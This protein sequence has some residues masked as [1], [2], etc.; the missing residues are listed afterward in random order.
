MCNLMNLVT[1]ACAKAMQKKVEYRIHSLP[2]TSVINTKMSDNLPLVCRE[3]PIK[4]NMCVC[5]CMCVLCMHV[6]LM[7]SV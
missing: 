2:G 3:M 6:Q 4:V 1:S 5:M 7:S